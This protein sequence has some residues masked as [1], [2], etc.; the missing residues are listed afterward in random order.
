MSGVKLFFSFLL[1]FLFF[2]LLNISFL[3][4]CSL[5]L[6]E[7]LFLLEGQPHTSTHLNSCFD[8][9]SYST[10]SIHPPA[11]LRESPDQGSQK[12]EQLCLSESYFPLERCG[13]RP[14]GGVLQNSASN[15]IPVGMK[16]DLLTCEHCKH[17]SFHT[18]EKKN[19][20]WKGLS[21]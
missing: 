13:L 10:E 12:T 15:N 8:L 2:F 16:K 9:S 14:E 4:S 20:E 5:L 11:L 6:H 19:R 21:F 3:L 18:H 7:S 17:M 1:S